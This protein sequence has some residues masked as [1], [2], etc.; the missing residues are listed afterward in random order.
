MTSKE[1][2]LLTGRTMDH[3]KLRFVIRRILQES[4]SEKHLCLDGSLVPI[5]SQKCF[6]DVSARMSDAIQTRNLCSMQSDARDHYNGIL[7]VLRRKHRRAGKF[8]DSHNT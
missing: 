8:I 2:F 5:E 4:S 1:L 7:K 6:D 3:K